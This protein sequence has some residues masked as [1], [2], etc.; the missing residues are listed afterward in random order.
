[1]KLAPTRRSIETSHVDIVLILNDVRATHDCD[2]AIFLLLHF[3]LADH[4]GEDFRSR[5]VIGGIFFCLRELLLQLVNSVF[6]FV[7]KDI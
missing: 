3:A 2:R 1:M 7:L 4:L 6:T 5:L